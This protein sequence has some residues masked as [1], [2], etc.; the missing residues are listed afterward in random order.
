MSRVP[1]VEL[2][3]YLGWEFEYLG[4]DFKCLAWEFQNQKPPFK[5]L[6]SVDLE[7]VVLYDTRLELKWI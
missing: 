6:K 1:Y 3:K 2:V 4:W 5:T 7:I